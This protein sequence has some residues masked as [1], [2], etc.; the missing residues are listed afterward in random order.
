MNFNYKDVGKEIGWDFKSMK[1]SVEQDN[2]YFYYHKVVE[3][4]SPKTVMLDIGCGSGE[5]AVKYFGLAK[6]VVML[7]NEIEMLKKSKENAEKLY[8]ADCEKFCFVEGDGDAKLDFADESFDLVVSRHCGANM[9]EVYRVLKKGGVFISEDIDDCDCMDIKEYYKRGQCYKIDYSHKEKTFKEAL[10]AG[11]E[12][13]NL[14]SFDQRE[15]YPDVEQLKYLLKRTPIIN[16][17]DEERD[18]K[19]LLKYAEDFTT[20][21]GILLKRQLYAFELRK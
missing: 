21:K 19:T 6:K 10:N 7:D 17:Y 16:G 13:I 9:K 5:K 2:P 14:L 4:I 11:F 12:E 8:G 1:H 18:E 3:Y 15:Y 20:D